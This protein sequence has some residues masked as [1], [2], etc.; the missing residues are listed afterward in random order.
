MGIAEPMR[1]DLAQRV[2]I[3][4]RGPRIGG[5]NRIVTEPLFTAG[6]GRTARVNAKYGA[7]DGVKTLQLSRVDGIR[8]S[9][10][11]EAQV[12]AAGIQKAVVFLSRIGRRVESNVPERVKEPV[13]HVGHPQQFP[14]GTV[15]YTGRRI[16]GAP[17][18][19]DV[20][21]GHVIG[22][23]AWRN[24]IRIGIV[25][26]RVL[27]MNGVEEPVAGKFRM[28]PEADKAALQS[29]VNAVRKRLGHIGVEGRLAI[30]ADQVEPAAGVVG[31]APAIRQVP[32]EAD[33]RPGVRIHIPLGR[34]LRPGVGQSRD[35]R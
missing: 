16:V 18:G 6:L 17:L 29:R 31:K 13:D 15:E 28:K 2:R 33:A 24:E 20:V 12:A 34:M 5:R 19:D 8:S 26:G 22:P 11:T 14:P 35:V 25:A 21:I 3:A 23:E 30:G 9:A 32:H 1:I 4:V 10:V 7:D 27:A